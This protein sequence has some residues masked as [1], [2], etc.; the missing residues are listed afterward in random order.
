MNN[1]KPIQDLWPA[2]TCYGCGPDNPQGMHIKSY[3]SE[4]GK[5]LIANYIP[6]KKY[7]AGFPNIMYGGTVA[8]LIDC[9]SIWTAI[10][11]TYKEQGVPLRDTLEIAYMTGKLSVHFIK[12]TPLDR[13]IK[14]RSWTSGPIGRKVHVICELGHD[15]EITATGEVIAVRTN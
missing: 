10:A 6:E 4:D 15:N 14:L 9:H 2:N 8:S 1:G 12:P 13:E 3:W 7:N 11:F 5:Y